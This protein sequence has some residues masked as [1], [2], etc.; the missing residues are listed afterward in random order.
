MART[1]SSA[2]TGP[3]GL[4]ATSNP[5]SIT[6]TGRV[7]STGGADG[8][9][10]G[11]GTVWTIAN[12]G[13]VSAATGFGIYLS[14]IGTVTSGGVI[15]GNDGVI[16]GSGGSLSNSGSIGATGA[17]GSGAW[18]GAGVLIN[19]APGT[20]T[21]SG[22]ITGPGY[23]ASVDFG[24]LVTN[25][26]LIIG[27][28]DGVRTG[29]ASGTG[30][31]VNSGTIIATADDGIGLLSGGTVSNAAGGLITDQN[32]V[33]AG[34]Y[35]G[36]SGIGTLTNSGRIT[37]PDYAVDIAGGG[38]V[39]NNAGGYISGN[40]GVNIQGGLGTVINSGSISG[41]T[42][43]GVRL[44]AGGQ[45]TNAAGGSISGPLGVAVYVAA[46]TITNSGTIT[47]TRHAVTFS[48]GGSNRLVAGATGVFI[49]DVVGSTISGS[50]N[51]LELAGGT[52]TL[53]GLAAGAGNVTEN[54]HSWAFRNF[55]ALAVDAGGTWTLNG[56]NSVASIANNGSLTI[57][58]SGALSVT[59]AVDPAS[60][61]LFSL[62]SNAVLDFAADVASG[63][64][65]AFQGPTG[66]LEL[67]DIAGGAVR[68][69]N[70]TIAGLNTGPSTT[71]PTNAI[72]IQATVTGA[73]LSGNTITVSNNATTV[74]TL[75]LSAAP[76]AGTSVFIH[77]DAKLGGYDVFLATIG[78]SLPT[79]TWSPATGTGVEAGA[80]A[81]GT[82][83]PSGTGLTSVLVSGIPIGATLGDGTHSFVASAGT[84]SVNVLGWTYSGLSIK[85]VNDANF[86]LSVQATDASSNVSAAASEAVT[87]NPLAPA[88]APVAVSGTAGQAIALNLGISVNGLSGD[89]NSLAS[90]TL[91]GIPAGATLSN[92]NGNPLTTSG[93]SI[94]F[95]AS[96]LAA[97]V[98]NGL[99]I[100]PASSGSI[101]LSIAAAEQDAQG[102][103][104]TTTNGTETLS[105]GGLPTVTWSPAT[106]TG[107]EAGAIALG[108]IAPSGTGLTSVLVSGIPIGATL[109]DGTHSF[110]A[111]AGT[112]S[113][114]VLGWT[115]SGLSIKPVNDANFSLSVQATDASSNVSA[116]ASEAVTVN[117]LAPAVAP[118]AVSGTAGQAIA[119]NL[120][121]SVNGLSGDSNSLASVTLGGI[122]AGATLSNTN[123]NPLT[124]SGGS[125]S[126]SASQLAAGV[127]NGLAITPASS[128]SITLSIAAAEQDAQGNL[129]TTTNGTETLTVSG[130]VGAGGTISTSVTGPINLTAANN[131]LTIT[132]TGRVTT[133]GS[134]NG[135]TG[136]SGTTWT[137]S[138]SGTISA[139]SGSASGIR[140][141][142]PGIVTNNGIITTGGS[143]Y[144]V[145]LDGGGT[146]TNTGTIIGGEDGVRI[147]TGIGTLINSGSIASKID[148]G[149]GFFAGGSIINAVGGSIGNLGTKGAGIYITGGVGTVTN[150]GALSGIDYVIDLA[151]GGNVTNNAG[152]TVASHRGVNI[153]GGTGT[154][155]NSGSITGTTSFGVRLQAG[156]QVNNAA[157]GW[158]SGTLGVGIYSAVGTVTNNGTISGS[159][160]A[161]TF[162]GGGSN[163]L[164]VGA[165]G[166]LIGDAVGST[167]S[168]SSNTLELAGGTG[169]LSGLTTA[170]AGNVNENGH[171][172]AFSNFSS[173]AV[174]AGGSWTMTGNDAVANLLNNGTVTI[175]ASA[176]LDVTTAINPASSGLFLLTGAST[177]EVASALG[178]NTQMSFLGASRLTIDK[179]GSFGSNVGSTNYAGPQLLGFTAGDTIDLLQFSA[180]NAGLAYNSATGVLQISN[181]ASQLASLDFQNTSLGSGSFHATSDG[182]SGAFITRS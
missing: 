72:D 141:S 1:I 5:L 150:S 35:F 43:F 32:T 56:T 109:G 24:G 117:P 108:T 118:V 134:G 47:G 27:G 23:G 61:G 28:E 53:D 142:G 180:A 3:V 161:V 59:A 58:N 179:F 86:S 169:T 13:T 158:I 148:D 170:G 103:L 159:R 147:T 102:N 52:G 137:V 15:T 55:N 50:S 178:T 91:G 76:A 45:M 84:I 153:L 115:Y 164:V 85:P 129:S 105:V 6:S 160:H 49:G 2:T 182:G 126:F 12:S 140:L 167:A 69:F 39:T 165:A 145:G 44:S 175:A 81:L 21:N 121:I 88:V 130:T 9:D 110:V 83:A 20:V 101:T 162:S 70:G 123:G 139:A 67:A 60:S 48:G 82:I 7:T 98:L 51:T 79:V 4:T 73:V 87:V 172:W 36:R 11:S 93:G 176:S 135:I 144:G 111:S 124:T 77:A 157:G 154:V 22:T 10:G 116:A 95:S 29:A 25:T 92:T 65:V 133:S 41:T 152:A 62:A 113:V 31:V 37:G 173:I 68:Q 34:I 106:G 89:S 16:L 151:K 38:G 64:Q 166:V 119:L 26:G 132:N 122:P 97:G 171:S 107:V 127:L 131:P 100:T 114:N 163:R 128:G 125:I 143:A 30:T 181:G 40:R 146:V 94:S 136:T 112:T 19:H 57:A 99:A 71:A 66:V 168:G 8:I 80:I 90:V 120:G 156:G 138:N 46:G 54:A 174:D 75:V 17:R 177:L 33:G 74:A 155:T 96:Q 18:T 63:V 78:P 14:G 42:S 104:S 149:I